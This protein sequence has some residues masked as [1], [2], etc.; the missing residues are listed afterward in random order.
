[1]NQKEKKIGFF[2]F[3]DEEEMKKR[4]IHAI[5]R[6]VGRFFRISGASKV[7]SLHFKLSD[8]SKGLGG[9][10]SLKTSAV[11]SIFAWKQTSP[12][13]RLPHTERPFQRQRKERKSVLEKESF[14]V[15]SEPG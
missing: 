15:S 7:C 4:W 6:D 5:R 13:K 3:P 1:M 10:K 12:R 11:P 9:R 14:S 8:M 2:K